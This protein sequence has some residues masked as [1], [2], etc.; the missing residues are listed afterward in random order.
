MARNV[1]MFCA[2]WG[3]LLMSVHL[4]I[5]WNMMVGMAKKAMKSNGKY[6]MTVK[7]IARGIAAAIAA[8]GIYAFWKRNIADYLFLIAHF[9]F[10]DFG[11]NLVCFLFD[12]VAIMALFVFVTDHICKWIAKR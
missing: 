6:S 4:G 3:F 1:H 7:W 12:Y 9:V 10:Y 2:Y 11:E 5:H 8:Y